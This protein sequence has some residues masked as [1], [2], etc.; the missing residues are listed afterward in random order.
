MWKDG[1]TVMDR[2]SPHR[3]RGLKP[4]VVTF[5]LSQTMSLPSPGAWIETTS[6][7]R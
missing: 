1:P 5:Q 2:R 7:A 4:L 6:T 3:E